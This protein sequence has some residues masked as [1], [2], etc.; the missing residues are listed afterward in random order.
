MFTESLWDGIE[1]VLIDAVGTLIEPHPSVA[2]VYLA[3]ASR[4]GVL[5]DRA[6]VRA[7]FHRFFRND[8][9]DEARGPLITDEAVEYRRWRRI[10]ANVL[11]EVSDSERAFTELWGH[12]ADSDSWRCFPDVGAAIR[13]LEMAEI[14]VRIASNFDGRLRRVVAGRAEIAGLGGSLVISSEVG[15][16]KPHPEFYLA[17][18]ASLGLEP[19]KVLCVGDDPENDVNGARRA[20][21]R[22]VLLDRSGGCVGTTACV[23]DL[24]RLMAARGGG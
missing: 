8:E 4:Q 11:P 18:C 3:A 1:G 20:G 24:G 5:I 2:D 16:R 12:F 15:Y 21:L 7:R 17:A 9:V 14:P 22:G 6:E 10:V 19:S 13:V 23:H